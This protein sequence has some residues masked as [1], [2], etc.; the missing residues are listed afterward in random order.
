MSLE[1]IPSQFADY[2]G[3][4]EATAQVILSVVIMF[5]ILLPALYLSRANKTISLI[6]IFFSLAIC[7]GLGWLPFWM[8]IMV[9]AMVAMAIALLGSRAVTGS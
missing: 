2:F 4:T 1:D 7:V 9:V 5:A 6:S 8:I 3:I